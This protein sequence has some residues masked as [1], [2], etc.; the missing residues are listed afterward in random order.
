MRGNRQGQTVTSRLSLRLNSLV[1]DSR[2][3]CRISDSE[4][5]SKTF[6]PFNRCAHQLL[7]PV[8]IVQPFTGLL[9]EGKTSTFPEFR[10]L[11][12]ERG[13]SFAVTRRLFLNQK[14]DL[15]LFGLRRSHQLGIAS[16]IEDEKPVSSAVRPDWRLTLEENWH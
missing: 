4:P 7:R 9:R 14:A 16:K 1:I 5:R 13:L 3:A 12:N 11:G 2:S 6:K 8:Q 10:K 15:P